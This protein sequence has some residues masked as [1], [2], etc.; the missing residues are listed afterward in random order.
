MLCYVLVCFL[1][2]L[3]LKLSGVAEGVALTRLCFNRML[4]CLDFLI[5]ALIII[6]IYRHGLEKF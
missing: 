6:I 2:L 5:K 4:I 1:Y 3:L